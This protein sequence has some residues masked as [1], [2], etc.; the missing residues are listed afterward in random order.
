MKKFVIKISLAFVVIAAVLLI[1]LRLRFC[2]T[3]D[4]RRWTQIER[5]MI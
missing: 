2:E 3:A 4:G 5:K 1:M